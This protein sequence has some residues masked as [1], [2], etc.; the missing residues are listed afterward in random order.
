MR[1]TPPPVESSFTLAPSGTHLARCSKLI[2]LGTQATTFGLKHRIF[3]EF[4]LCNETDEEGQPLRVSLWENYSLHEKANFRKHLESWRGK[5]YSDNDLQSI[6]LLGVLGAPAMLAIV[7]NTKPDGSTY[8]NI[9]SISKAPKGTDTPELTSKT[10]WLSLNA[11]EFDRDSYETLSDSLKA[12]IALSPQFQ[13]IGGPAG[14][15]EI[16]GFTDGSGDG[17]PVF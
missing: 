15:A 13:E 16:N 12:K 11:G 10:T 9:T 1:M 5:Q 2:D 4:V 8:A 17:E 7:H 6:D 14:Q 3:L